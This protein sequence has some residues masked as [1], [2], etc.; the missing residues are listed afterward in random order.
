MRVTHSAAVDTSQLH[1]GLRKLINRFQDLW[2][3][4]WQETE[5]ARHG[6]VDQKSTAQRGD[7]FNH[8]Y[9]PE[10]R[11]YLSALCIA[12]SPDSATME[13]AQARPMLMGL[14]VGGSAPDQAPLSVNTKVKLSI[15]TGNMIV[16]RPNYG[17][18]CPNWVPPDAPIPVDEGDGIDNA[19]PIEVRE[20]IELAR[21]S[22]IEF[23]SAAQTQY[24]QDEWIAGQLVRFTLDQ[25]V[26]KNSLRAARRCQL[27]S[28][29]CAALL[30]LAFEQAKNYVAAEVAFRRSDSIATSKSRAPG[31]LCVDEAALLLLR[32]IDRP[33]ISKADCSMQRALLNRMWWLA[34]PLWGVAGN[35]RYVAHNTRTA[36]VRL[37]SIDKR[38]ER[39][40]WDFRNGGRAVW[41][42]V[43]RYG[44]PSYTFWPG[45][46]LQNQIQTVLE[47]MPARET[48]TPYT[49]KEYLL[50]QTALIPNIDAIVQPYDVTNDSW[51]LWR[52]EAT[53]QDEWWAPEHMMYRTH[54]VPMNEGQQGMWRRDGEIG[55]QLAVDDPLTNRDTMSK[56]LTRAVLWGGSNPE[57]TRKFSE[58]LIDDGHTLRLDAKFPSVPLVLSAE[59]LPRTQAEQ[60]QRNRFGVKPPPTL[61]EM[62]VDD[63]A[64]SD[65]VFM[66][67]PNRDMELPTDE[68][69]VLRYMAGGLEFAPAEPVALYWESYGFVRGDTVQ[70]E[71]KIRRDDKVNVARKV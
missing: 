36:S 3:S 51:D 68:T 25:R 41:E 34:D 9:T 24:P 63:F 26:P 33:K 29:E 64:L 61:R 15:A 66:R 55:F 50:D 58:T 8:N 22:L 13:N 49:V 11:R 39:Y 37:R 54:L 14:T 16:P 20:S 44:W 31:D 18:L 4:T 10:V 7:L 38:D 40:V 23:L 67:M 65:P 1:D 70:V 69:S 43:I 71:L 27:S 56:D 5:M 30:G 45:L 62:K 2:R 47:L 42:M 17:P 52:P 46:A 12:G 57:S 53:K 32:R 21:D 19:L 28:S 35:E 48:R 59:I 6:P 60:A